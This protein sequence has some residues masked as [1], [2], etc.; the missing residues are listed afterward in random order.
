MAKIK[1]TEYLQ[2]DLETEQWQC[3]SCNNDLIS[4]RENFKRGLLVYDRDPR[5][6]HKPLLDPERYEFTFSPDPDWCRILEFYCPSCGTM[7]EAEYTVPGHP[8]IHD[9]E[10]DIDA[11][12]R[13][14]EGKEQIID[15]DENLP[16]PDPRRDL[17]H[18]HNH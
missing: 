6:I 17:G 1:I 3:R 16:T 15:Q 18:S 11:L 7:V 13:R 9:L 4:A 12:K 8:P 10:L 5:Q 2:I 14:W